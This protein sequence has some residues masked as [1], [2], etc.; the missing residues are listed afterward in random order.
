MFLREQTIFL[1]QQKVFVT[2]N[3]VVTTSEFVARNDACEGNSSTIS[4]EVVVRNYN[5]MPSFRDVIK[6]K[7]AASSEVAGGNHGAVS[8]LRHMVKIKLA[9]SS[10]VVVGIFGSCRWKSLC[11]ASISEHGQNISHGNGATS[12]LKHEGKLSPYKLW[13][14]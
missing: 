9:V 10:E 1:G 8:A 4:S 14:R 5:T 7:P 13:N 12:A 2:T 6:I 11:H 3:S